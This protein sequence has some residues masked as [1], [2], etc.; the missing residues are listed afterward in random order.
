MNWGVFSVGC[1]DSAVAQ[2]DASM[3]E[4][5]RQNSENSTRINSISDLLDKHSPTVLRAMKCFNCGA[6][7]DLGQKCEYC[8]AITRM[9]P[10]Y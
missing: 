2:L 6:N 4:A 1:I 8:G 5:Q 9:L 7:A 10:Q 3:K